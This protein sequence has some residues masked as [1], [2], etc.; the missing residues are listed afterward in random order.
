MLYIFKDLLF[1]KIKLV[2]DSHS[3]T[4]NSFPCLWLASYWFVLV[5]LITQLL[6]KIEAVSKFPANGWEQDLQ[7]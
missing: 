4:V 6:G 7:Q 2:I 1:W 5:F 3:A